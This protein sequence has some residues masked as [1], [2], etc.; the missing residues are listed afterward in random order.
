M[1]LRGAQESWHAVRV[2]V[3]YKKTTSK[4]LMNS[5]R[6]ILFLTYFHM[7]ARYRK[8]WAG[9]LWVI[10][11]PIL[12]FLV[13]ALIFKEIFKFN[14]DRYPLFLLAGLLPWF[15][16]SQTL[17]SVTSCLVL[18]R[19]VLLAF[20]IPPYVIVSSQ[21]LDQF[22]SFLAAFIIMGLFLILP[23]IYTYSFF[24]LC[25]IPINL[26]MI[27]Y[28]VLVL[29]TLLSFWHIFFRDVHFIIQ[30][31]MSLAFYVTPIFYTFEMF[32]AKYKWLLLINF[33]I[34]FIKIF[35][36]S[37]YLWNLENWSINI[38]QTL[39]INIFL[40][41]LLLLSFKLKMRDFYINV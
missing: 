34:P 22:L 7:C 2:R 31:V 38:C 24:R 29:T 27:L 9:F 4:V 12:T 30:F 14:I 28:F 35:Q 1:S 13:Q 36:T 41:C 8:T 17:N 20:K 6:K 25:T 21:V 23:H 26:L 15:F 32:P 19:E 37:I 10:S 16:I 39:L 40:T 33:F 18:S 5:I 11:S 3:S